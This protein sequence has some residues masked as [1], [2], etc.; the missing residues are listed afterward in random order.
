MVCR[1]MNG[2][3]PEDT[4]D[5]EPHDIEEWLA[6]CLDWR[7]R[8]GFDTGWHNLAEKA[9]LIVTEVSEMVEGHRKGDLA[10]AR[11]EMADIAIRLFDLA[12]STDTDLQ[13]EMIAKMRKN[14]GR[15]DKH[16]KGY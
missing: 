1:M 16:G 8:K 15:P 10:N 9:M 13:E 7:K 14:E 6:Y 4:W 2:E 12:A 11:E 5:S 3:P